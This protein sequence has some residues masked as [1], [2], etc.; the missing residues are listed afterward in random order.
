M[1]KELKPK[2]K[3]VVRKNLLHTNRKKKPTR[4]SLIHPTR[5]RLYRPFPETEICPRCSGLMVKEYCFDYRDDSGKLAFLAFR[6]ILCGEMIDPLI[7]KNRHHR[8]NRRQIQR[9]D[10][11][12]VLRRTPKKND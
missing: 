6:C 10:P 7:I 8:P 4:H 5:V 12:T 2:K 1:K 3:P 9:E 11:V